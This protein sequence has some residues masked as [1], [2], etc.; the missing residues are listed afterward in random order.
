MNG[1]IWKN[2]VRRWGQRNDQT[3]TYRGEVEMR[4]HSHDARDLV[5]RCYAPHFALSAHRRWQSVLV[6]LENS[7]LVQ[8]NGGR[9]DAHVCEDN[10]R[11]PQTV[12]QLQVRWK[13]EG[14][15]EK[16]VVRLPVPLPELAVQVVVP[17][18]DVWAV[19]MD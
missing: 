18:I 2:N 17:V 12:G 15:I 8:A 3:N 4:D 16:N 5:C 9:M 7:S 19:Q 10:V 11:V 6:G 1:F 13:A 14:G